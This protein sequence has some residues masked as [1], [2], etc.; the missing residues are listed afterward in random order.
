VACGLKGHSTKRSK[1]CLHYVGKGKAAVPPIDL[2]NAAASTAAPDA[3]KD[4]AD[5]DTLPLVALQDD[6]PDLALARLNDQDLCDSEGEDLYT[7]P[8]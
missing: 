3:A 2:T 5:F 1:A 6:D 4:T 8:I 7:G